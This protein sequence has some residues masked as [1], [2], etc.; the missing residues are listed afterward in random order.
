M[1]CKIQT[2]RWSDDGHATSKLKHVLS[3]EEKLEVI[4]WVYGG[5]SA[6]LMARA[7][8]IGMHT[9]YDYLEMPAV[10]TAM[11]ISGSWLWLK[12]AK[13]WPCESL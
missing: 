2:S 10:S 8:G 12:Q 6:T 9:V 5:E 7:F 1:K 4:K 11:D 3:L 13:K